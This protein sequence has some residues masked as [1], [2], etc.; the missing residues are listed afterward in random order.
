MDTPLG[1]APGLKRS[2]ILRLLKIFALKADTA[3][4]V[5]LYDPMCVKVFTHIG[6][7]AA[8][9]KKMRKLQYDILLG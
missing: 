6:F 5:E 9:L 8:G 3:T 7:K 1:E 4:G 2:K